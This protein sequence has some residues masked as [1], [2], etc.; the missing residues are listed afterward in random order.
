MPELEVLVD[1]FEERAA[2]IQYEGGFPKE[3]AEQLAAE[4]LGFPD[5]SFFKQYVSDLKESY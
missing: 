4:G 2:I 1:Q 3:V 5:V